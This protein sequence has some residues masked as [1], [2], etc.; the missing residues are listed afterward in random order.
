MIKNNIL[1]TFISKYSLSNKICTFTKNSI[2]IV[3]FGVERTLFDYKMNFGL[4]DP[5]LE[6]E[7]EQDIPDGAT[8]ILLMG[9]DGCGKTT[10]F[11]NFLYRDFKRNHSPTQRLGHFTFKF[12]ENLVFLQELGGSDSFAEKWANYYSGKKGLIW[13]VDSIDRG[14]V[15]ESREVIDSV[16]GDRATAD[17][18]VLIILNKQDS[19]YKMTDEF[20]SKYFSSECFSD[21]NTK[22]VKASFLS[23]DGVHDG[24]S[25]LMNEIIRND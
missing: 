22:V 3:L 2:K 4:Y 8:P 21:R 19:K 10:L 23:L 25:W 14:R 1:L 17:M 6:E 24:F 12:D 11:H 5:A 16:L 20:I 7:E 9:L 15:I 18:P 13:I